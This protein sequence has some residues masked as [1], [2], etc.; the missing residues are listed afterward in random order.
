VKA[1][2]QFP[3]SPYCRK[4]L[5]VRGTHQHPLLVAAGSAYM[6]LAFTACWQYSNIQQIIWV[7]CYHVNLT[8]SS[9][10][11]G[12]LRPAI[13]TFSQTAYIELFYIKLSDKK[14]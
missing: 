11:R 8:L 5:S 3:A 10:R 14:F 7:C 12:R 13:W 6:S 2:R 9:K 1:L 4:L